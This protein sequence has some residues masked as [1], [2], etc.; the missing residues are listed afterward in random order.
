MSYPDGTLAGD[1]PR[2]SMPETF[3]EEMKRYI[4]FTADDA[5][6]LSSLA[7]VV[8][9]HLPALANRFY[10][11][12]PR[13]SEAA[14]VFTGGETQIARL[15]LTLQRWARGLFSGVYDEAYAQERFRIGYRHV[16]I[17]LAQRYVISAMHVVSFFLREVLDREIPD[18]DRRHRAHESLSRIVILDLA[19]ICET[20]FEGSLRELTQLNARL[21]SAN[22]SLEEANRVKADFLATTSHE[23]RTPLTSIIGFSRLLLDSYVTNPAEQ[24]DLLADV[25]RSALHLLSLVDD[26]L[27]L[28]RIDAGRLEITPETLDI[29]AQI[30]EVATLTKVQANEKGLALLADVPGDLPPVRV[31]RSRM[32]QIL[33]N[34]IGNAIKF[35]EQGGIRV[36]AATDSDGARVRVDVTD[37][38][39]GIAPEQQPLLFERFRQLD[40]SHTRKHGGA[41]LGLAIS[42]V[43]IERMGGR[44]HVRSH[45]LG[46]GTTVTLALPVTRAALSDEASR[47]EANPAPARPSILLMGQDGVERKVIVAALRGNG[48]VVREASTADGVRALARVERPDLLLIDLTNASGPDTVGQ[49]LD[50]LVALH[51]DPQTQSIRPVVLV[52]RAVHAATIAR[53]ELLPIRPAIVDKDKPFDAGNLK[54]MLERIASG[55]REA[56]LRVLVAD[57]DPMVFK[58]VT[59]ILPPHEYIVQ[60]AASG[61]EVLRALDSQRFDAL[62][63]DLRMP[64][65][66]GYDVIRSLKLEGRAP[67]LPILVI[68]NYPAPTDVEEQALLSSPLI[69]DVLPKP[70][71]AAQPE[72]LLERLKT[73]RSES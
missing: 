18:A 58:F 49:W 38:G 65:E 51:G 63:L 23:L 44:I 40:A 16:Q 20:Y 25:H 45:G 55:P 21:T 60:H 52:D 35:T 62:L 6:T 39:I 22:R 53:V 32:R 72:I 33:L 2:H 37:T 43:L 71:V 13:H 54:R 57:D 12:I 9:P 42:K 48:Y 67:D 66:S 26:I 46:L 11:Q 5:A 1:F 17:G 14:A 41:G 4:G 19:L 7:P 10:E 27:D 70:I 69:L 73:I 68:T 31:D 24:R 47:V 61:R 56:P 29:A 64:D 8:E 59:S 50:L 34:V 15:Q 36:V 3:L 28:S 30:A